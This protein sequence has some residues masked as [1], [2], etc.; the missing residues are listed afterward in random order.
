MKTATT[1]AAA[2]FVRDADAPPALDEDIETGSDS[3]SLCTMADGEEEV[4]ET[5]R[6]DLAD[7]ETAAVFRLRLL[8]LL[9]LLVAAVIV[10]VIVYF[11][12]ST[13]QK[14]EYKTQYEGAAKKVLDSF[15]DIMDSKLGAVSSMGVAIIGELT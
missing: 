6:V 11:I 9:V 13:A 12:T 10:T 14:D 8:V 1:K 7:K 3:G 2:K 4:E 15:L 5:E